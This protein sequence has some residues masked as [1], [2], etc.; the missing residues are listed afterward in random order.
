MSETRLGFGA[1]GL[2]NH[3]HAV[4]DAHATALLDAAWDS[5]VRH[6]DTAPHYG[7][8]LS[9]RRLGAFLAG[10]P[11][12]EFTVSTKVGR[13]L[14]P[15]PEGAD[16]LD[17]EGF[18]VPADH[19][20]VWDFTEA[21]V[22]RSLDD[23]LERLGLERVDVLYL[24]DPERHDLDRG[25]A[26]GLPALARLREEGLVGSIGVGSM[27]TAAL[28]AAVRSGL[29]DQLMVAGRY[30]LTDQSAVDDVLPACVTYGVS[31]V[32][33]AVF[34][35]GLL[36]TAPGPGSTFD[37]RAA[38]P[39]VVAHARELDDVCRAH[40]VSLR[41]AALQYPLRHPVVTTVVAGGA[42]PEHIRQN[43]EL[44]ATPIPDALWA[45]LNEREL[46]VA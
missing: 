24:H 2:G 4:T 40:G 3:G 36:A 1:A 21:G 7:L 42:E 9:E 37:Y 12:A 6:F 32:A 28:L 26:E 46:V 23:S 16:R 31:V 25:I 41:A 18:A 15:W 38:T 39:D 30:T 13:L 5:G 11:R 35:G 14:E 44:L 33:A 27:D 8:G 43:V 22:R 20:R 29:A 45:D 17:D 34:N 19:R 10:K